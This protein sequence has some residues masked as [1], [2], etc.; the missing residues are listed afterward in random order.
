MAFKIDTEAM[1]AF[2]QRLVRTPS[3]SAREEQVAALVAEEMRQ[4]GLDEVSVDRMGNVIGRVGDANG[5]KLLYDAHMDTVDVGELS[6]WPHDP[7]C[8]EVRHGVLYGLGASDMKGALAAMLYG[9]KSLVDA[10]RPLRGALY[11]VG[12]VQEEPCEGLAIQ[13]VIEADGLRPDW[14]LIGEATNLH[15]ARGQ[16]GRIELCI[17]VHGRACHASAPER[18]VN[19]IYE[20]ARVIVGLELLASKLSN[21]SFLGKGSIAVTE[22][23]SKSPSRNAVP[24][25]CVLYVDRRL[26]N[27]ET[28]AKALAEIRRV[29]AQEGVNATVE[30]SEY[31][32][33]SYTGCEVAARQNFAPWVTAE[34]EPIVRNTVAVIEEVLGYAPHIGRW[35]FSTDGVYTA[36]VAGIPTVGFGPGEERYVHTVDDHVRIRDLESAAKVYAALAARMLA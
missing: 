5:P 16:R 8:G 4:I 14:V 36:G 32:D 11:I 22:I 31:R 24:D 3:P 15:V 6:A 25:C 9:A 35:D 23:S 33:V 10:G 21:D 13:H 7:Y 27:G 19:A 29:I 17:T 34:N 18:G 2:A 20:A 12:V 1:T 26:T 30:V 28:E